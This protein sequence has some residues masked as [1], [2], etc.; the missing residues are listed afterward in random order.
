MFDLQAMTTGEIEES[1]YEYGA[2]LAAAL[3]LASSRPDADV[4]MKRDMAK[5]VL[6]EIDTA[7]TTLR[8]GYAPML[9]VASYEEA[10]RAGVRDGLQ[11]GMQHDAQ[12]RHAA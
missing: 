6:R 8:R 10:L 7:V 12:S 3:V 4:E 9:L 11:R 1:G 5:I 2:E